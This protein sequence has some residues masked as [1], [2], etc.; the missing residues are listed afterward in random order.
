MPFPESTGPAASRAGV[1][2]GYLDYF[3]CLVVSKVQWLSGAELRVSLLPSGWTVLEL[4]QHLAPP[5]PPAP[6]PS[7]PPQLAWVAVTAH[8]HGQDRYRGSRRPGGCPART[9]TAG[10]RA[11]AGMAWSGSHM[12][13]PSDPGS[14]LWP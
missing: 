14:P 7:P 6:C 5:K 10:R 11:G 2:L 12:S 9:G 13:E 8:A 4:V 1:L 3:R